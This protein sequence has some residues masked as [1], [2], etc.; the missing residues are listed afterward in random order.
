MKKTVLILLTLAGV[1][2][3]QPAPSGGLIKV[4]TDSSLQ[5]A[6]TSPSP[7]GLLHCV[8]TGDGLVWNATTSTWGCGTA[9]G[10]VTTVDTLSPLQ[11][12]PI[13]TS[14][15][16]SLI[17][18][19]LNEIYKST[20]GTGAS[21]W[22]CAADADTT[23][24]A[25]TGI[26]L[27]GTTFSLAAI[28]NNTILG[29][30]SGAS[31][32]PTALT[33][34]Q[35]TALLDAF[36]PTLKGLAPASGGGTANYLRAD[37]TWATPP[38]TG[39][40][41]T[42]TS[43]DLIAAT[44]T[45]TVGNFAG[46]TPPAC[47]AGNVTT[48]VAIG[49]NGAV[50]NTCTAIGTAGG[51]TG[52]GTINTLPMWTSATALGDSIATGTA[53]SITIDNGTATNVSQL[54]AKRNGVGNI[55]LTNLGG[56]N[57]YLAFGAHYD[58]TGY[59]ADDTTGLSIGKYGGGP[60]L[61]IGTNAAQTV[62]SATSFTNRV[63]L[64]MSTG[65]WDFTSPVQV[66]G[67]ATMGSTLGV[68]GN[69]TLCT[70]CV[71]TSSISS[72]NLVLNPGATAGTTSIAAGASMTGGITIGAAGN[73]T[74]IK[75]AAT[76]DSTLGV[77]GNATLSADTTLGG[78]GHVLNLGAAHV[79]AK[80]TTNQPTLTN[81]GTSPTLVGTDSSGYFITG[82]S[83]TGTCTLTFHTAF[84]QA[85]CIVISKVGT[86]SGQVPAYDAM[87]ITTALNVTVATG[88]PTTTVIWDCKDH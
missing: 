51:T 81:C 7:L 45:A 33:G 60:D 15:T 59:I 5:G 73:P 75:G 13:T 37:G 23:Y 66:D 18:C 30:V 25:G 31:A 46:S 42:I 1:A 16:V 36:T 24:T 49:A 20:G 17:S 11:G 74:T 55:A 4:K 82:A 86:A 34:T 61:L 64:N 84:T 80:D 9:G 79:T 27:G 14:G 56:G 68:G 78:V 3:A 10:T 29:N 8:T 2:R 26:T 88:G 6:G 62:G 63:I 39:I 38:D 72:S 43:G 12:G 83:N 48:G 50:T 57:E 67:A 35:V 69:T 58:G 77:T 28:A 87:P 52:T 53:S 71:N 21:A 70:G 65:L 85:S 19:P 76:L 32:S 44:G 54:Q 40:T 47:T 22:A 41:G